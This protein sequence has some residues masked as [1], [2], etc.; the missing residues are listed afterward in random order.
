MENCEFQV[1]NLTACKSDL[2]GAGFQVIMAGVLT[3]MS[4][5]IFTIRTMFGFIVTHPPTVQFEHRGQIN[6]H[7]LKDTFV[8]KILEHVLVF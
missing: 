6:V 3:S 1:S 5:C 2:L 8:F 7:T 4:S